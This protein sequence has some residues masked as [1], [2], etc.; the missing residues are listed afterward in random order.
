MK[1][2]IGFL[3]L[4]ISVFSTVVA[5]PADPT[6]RKVIQPNGDTICIFLHGDEFGSWYENDKGD[7]ISRNNNGY[8]VYVS[9]ENNNKILTNQIVSQ[10]SMPID[11]NRDSIFNFII[12][13]RSN[14]YVERKKISEE[15]VNS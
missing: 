6:M 9:V 15:Q 4:S 3:L 2:L 12:Q 13:K 8:W 11:I 14:N 7:I 10:T 1:R 5:S